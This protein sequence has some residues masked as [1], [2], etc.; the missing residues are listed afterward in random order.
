MDESILH[1]E[2]SFGGQKVVTTLCSRWCSTDDDYGWIKR[3]YL[4]Y[5]PQDVL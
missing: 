3:E 5:I 4:Q 2:M 1:Q